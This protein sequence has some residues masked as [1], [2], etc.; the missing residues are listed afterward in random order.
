MK[1]YPFLLVLAA[2]GGSSA[3]PEPDARGPL[4][5]PT[6]ARPGP[7][8][9]S[10]PGEFPRACEMTYDTDDRITRMDCAF[11]AELGAGGACEADEVW[12]W[13]YRVDGGVTITR[14]GQ[15]CHSAVF[16]LDALDVSAAIT[17]THRRSLSNYITETTMTFEGELVLTRH[18]FEDQLALLDGADDALLGSQVTEDGEPTGETHTYSYDGPP[19]VGVRTRTR[20]D[21]AQTTFEYDGQ[22]RLIA[23]S[24][25]DD[26]PAR[27]Y[28]YDGD[29]LVRDGTVE[30]EHD[31]HGNLIR[32]T[33]GD[34]VMLYDY[35]CWE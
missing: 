25:D 33:D 4:V 27:T 17:G 12:T 32:R 7:C 14:R 8:S 28:A 29:R 21:G 19:H 35:Y 9:S 30:Y 2:C 13:V 18:P 1:L 10:M 23:T 20:D 34:Q 5:L 22:G 11:R 16:Y 6:A 3:A 26:T 15:E 24:G 31:E